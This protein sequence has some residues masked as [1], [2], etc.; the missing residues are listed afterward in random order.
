M[1]N[2]ICRYFILLFC[3][4]FWHLPAYAARAFTVAQT[5]PSPAQFDM[6]VNNT[7][8]FRVTNTNTGGTTDRIT[9][10]RFRLNSTGSTFPNSPILPAGW[11]FT[12]SSNKSITFSTTFANGIQ[13]GAFLDFSIVING[14]ATSADTTER[15]RDVRAT[16]TT[17]G[18]STGTLTGNIA[19][20]GWTVKSLVVT[21]TVV[22][23]TPRSCQFTLTMTVKNNSTSAITN[24]TSVPTPP[25]ITTTGGASAT[26][27][28]TPPTFS[29]NAGASN[30]FAW[31]YNTGATAGTLTFTASA[32]DGGGTRTSRT[33]S[34]PVITVT[35]SSCLTAAFTSPPA[36]GACVFSGDTATFTVHV[37]NGTGVALTNVQ[38]SVPTKG[39]TATIGTLNPATQTAVPLANGASV[40]FT[41]TAPI[42]GNVDDTY[43]ISTTVTSTGGTN[44]SASATSDATA[45]VRGYIVQE[46]P[47]VNASST[48]QEIILSVTNH[49]C[50]N[51]T[52]ILVATPAGWTWN[53]DSYSLVNGTD[54]GALAWTVTASGLNALFTAPAANQLAV[55]AIG[56]FRL[57]YTTPSTTGTSTFTLTVTDSTSLAKP[58]SDTANVNSFNSGSPN[59]NATSTGTWREQF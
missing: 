55:G 41:W 3:L 26:T 23:S 31:I 16:F 35:S 20:P 50:N 19:S 15:F 53:G 49:A 28:S 39:G 6:A 29:L 58:G 22:T 36:G 42:I 11:S 25:T 7:G 27:I 14:W 33:V 38:P 48:N 46:S 5:S 56:E 24:V 40:D 44:P 32:K 2:P 45:D 13:P 9:A 52:S 21:W 17:S 34:P 57:V 4:A 30:S 43:F 59:S 47:D 37:T 10:V 51:V 12:Y 8:I 18:G 54:S 1:K